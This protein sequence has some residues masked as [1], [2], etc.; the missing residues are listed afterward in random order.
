MVSWNK[1]EETF[2]LKKTG[3]SFKLLNGNFY[4]FLENDGGKNPQ[5]FHGC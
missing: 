2:S 3:K 5:S 1:V 4:Y